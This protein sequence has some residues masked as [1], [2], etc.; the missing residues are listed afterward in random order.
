M[1]VCKIVLCSLLVVLLSKQSS[2]IYDLDWLWD[3][4]EDPAKADS[5][6]TKQQDCGC[7]QYGSEYWKGCDIFGQCECYPNVQGT[8]CDQCIYG[9]WNIMSG[10]GCQ[11]CGCDPEGALDSACDQSTGQCNCKE[12]FG[13]TSC[14]ACG[15]NYYGSPQDG[16]KACECSS[17]GSTVQ[18]CGADGTC[19]CKP[20]IFGDKCDKC[21]ENYYDVSRGCLQCPY[22]YSAINDQVANLRAMILQLQQLIDDASGGTSITDPTFE[23]R[24]AQTEQDA[25]DLLE[26]LQGGGTGTGG[27]IDELKDLLNNLRAKVSGIQ[28]NVDNG[29]SDANDAADKVLNIRGIIAQITT[30]M[31]DMKDYMENEGKDIIDAGR[32]DTGATSGE[33]D[34]L[35]KKA[36]DL[37]N[38][39]EGD[40]QKIEDVSNNA[41]DIAKEALKRIKG[42]LDSGGTD[43]S[44]GALDDLKAK[45]DQAAAD[46]EKVKREADEALKKAETT[47]ANARRIL[48]N[49]EARQSNM[50]VD[51]LKDQANK[52]KGESDDLL[53]EINKL[54][55][56]G[57]AVVND[58][59]TNHDEALKQ[60]Q[61]ARKQIQ[62]PDLLMARADAARQGADAAVNSAEAIL[63]DAQKTL[64]TLSDFANKVAKAESDAKAAL[65][66]EPNIRAI[67]VEAE[68]ATTDANTA[69]G[70]AKT[71]AD[72]AK[73][74]AEEA[75]RIAD[76]TKTS[77]AQEKE[78]A[79]RLSKKAED[80]HNEA[81]TLQADV[82][83]FD[84][85]GSLWDQKKKQ[86]DRDEALIAEATVEAQ[87][88]QKE[89][90][91]TFNLMVDTDR[92]L[93]A[94]LDKLADGSSAPDADTMKTLQ[95]TYDNLKGQWDTLNIAQIV[96]NINRWMQENIVG[97]ADVNIDMLRAEVD[98]LEAIR[99]AL[100]DGCFR[101]ETGV[102]G[103]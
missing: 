70:S 1:A 62:R 66:K 26:Q 46:L 77:A 95:Q 59:T 5:D 11:S 33:F 89:A 63:S 78:R 47:D 98:N 55:T 14:D 43:S 84:N 40:A 72:D 24:L 96:F 75:K 19:S 16:C 68:T 41:L 57:T 85:T 22:C 13:G 64:E 17:D 4:I 42:A 101:A 50:D 27:A 9:Y 73:N 51:G 28:N 65:T 92:R 38:E 29:R 79:D 3:S 81:K 58:V 91:D 25:A 83:N 102:E 61:D 36:Q 15:P 6:D 94:I 10:T 34:E 69:L 90:E 88:I 54:D 87:R 31:A 99:N 52:I 7:S 80:L 23:A 56:D 8:K 60:L 20:D 44:A 48:A 35:V 93:Q 49:A 37:A 100:P 32:G 67:I 82:D 30:L 71:D 21:R 39:Q 76:N 103:T 74:T 2:G 45:L 97:V 53:R 18:Q 86:G 12:G